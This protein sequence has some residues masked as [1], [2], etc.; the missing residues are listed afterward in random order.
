VLQLY[1]D[2]VYDL[3]VPRLQR[4]HDVIPAPD[5]N[6]PTAQR[7]HPVEPKADWYLPA[8]HFRHLLLVIS[9]I[10]VEYF[11]LSHRR[12]DFFELAPSDD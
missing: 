9:P 7:W 1:F 2:P 5:A 12:H 6:V 10:P 8:G 11:P 4:W 3:K